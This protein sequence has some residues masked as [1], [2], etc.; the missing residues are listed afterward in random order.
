MARSGGG[1]CTSGMIGLSGAGGERFYGCEIE[2]VSTREE[3]LEHLLDASLRRARRQV[4]NRAHT[5]RRHARRVRLVGRRRR[6]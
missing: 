5:R 2:P 4:Q 3:L 1:I 6:A